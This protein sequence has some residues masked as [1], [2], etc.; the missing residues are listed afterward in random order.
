MG[1]ETLRRKKGRRKKKK[2][3]KGGPEKTQGKRYGR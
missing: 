2:K 1:E 3:G